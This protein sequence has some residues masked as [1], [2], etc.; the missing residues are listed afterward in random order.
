MFTLQDVRRSEGDRPILDGVD[1][2][3]ARGAVTAI[4]GPSGAGKTSLLRLLNRL[5]TPDSGDVHFDGRPI[6]DYPVRQLRRLV[7]FVF[8]APVMFEGTVRDNLQIAATLAQRPLDANTLLRA[9]GLDTSYAD[10]DATTLSGGERQRV[11]IARALAT[12]PDA[13]LLDEPTAALD[14]DVADT[15]MATIHTLSRDRGLTTV[16]VTHRLVEART[17]S[18]MTVVLDAGRVVETG[19]TETLFTN[20]SNSRT[21]AYL[22]VGE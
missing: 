17:A 22:R 9:A 7:A 8:Q 1:L 15:L 21:R 12:E 14:P 11:S 2:E 13:L 4:V 18:T 19:P 3:I 16:M 5:D 10:R 6:V 20:P